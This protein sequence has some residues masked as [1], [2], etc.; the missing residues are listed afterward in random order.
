[1][2]RDG[3]LTVSEIPIE[4][5]R[6]LGSTINDGTWEPIMPRWLG[7]AAPGSMSSSASGVSSPASSSVASPSTETAVNGA[8]TPTMNSSAGSRSAGIVSVA[9]SRGPSTS[10]TRSSTRTS[11]SANG[12]ILPS[13]EVPSLGNPGRTRPALDET[14]ARSFQSVMSLRRDDGSYL[15]PNE[16]AARPS[17]PLS[18]PGGYV[19]V[20]SAQKRAR[21][22]RVA[23]GSIRAIDLNVPTLSLANLPDRPVAARQ[24]GS[25]CLR[26]S[27]RH[28]RLRRALDHYP[29]AIE[30]AR[31]RWHSQ[32][33]PD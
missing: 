22:T 2:G 26:L 32:R 20:R 5:G 8:S 28:V 18:C 24:G 7:I 30:A 12:M 6:A 29:V 13:S 25:T 1:M 17:R 16:P 14:L 21:K 9:V 31:I 23:K 4:A 27:A 19:N 3:A 10:A 11:R 33:C 15:L